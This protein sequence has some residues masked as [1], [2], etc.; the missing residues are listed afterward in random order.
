MTVSALGN[1][2]VV[3]DVRD[4]PRPEWLAL[5]RTGI[6]GSDAAAIC[7]QSQYKSALE[8]WLEK[9]G[10]IGEQPDNERMWWGRELEDKIAYKLSEKTGVELTKVGALLAHP[11]HEWMLASPDRAAWDPRR[12]GLGAEVGISELKTAGYFPG[13]E[14]KGRDAKVPDAYV[15]QGMHYLAVCNLPFVLFGCLIDFEVVPLMVERDDELIALLMDREAEFWEMVT[16]RRPPPPDGSK[17]TTDLLTALYDLKPGAVV[18][19]DPAEVEPIVEMRAI[20][21]AAEK[22]AKA[23]KDEASNRLRR[24]IGEHEI[25]NAPDGRKLFSWKQVTTHKVDTGL[26]AQVHTEIVEGFIRPSTYRTI[27]VPKRKKA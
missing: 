24:M 18:T 5:R 2:R 20:A 22:A 8:V 9:T 13:Q 25:A 1:A 11:E 19:L 6:G 10:A 23:Q 26:L 14:W 12:I 3:A 7:G 17:A 21:A 15:L 16:E 27:H 4:M